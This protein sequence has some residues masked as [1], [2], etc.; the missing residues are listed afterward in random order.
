MANRIIAYF[1]LV[2]MAYHGRHD[3]QESL[4]ANND[5]KPNWDGSDPMKCV[6]QYRARV[7]VEYETNIGDAEVVKERRAS[8]ALRLTGGLSGKAWDIIE[9]LLAD[10]APMKVY[11]A[12]RL[13]LAALNTLDKEAVLTKPRKV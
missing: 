1:V 11:G 5:G 3:R 4:F 13:A 6:K 9:P 2:L 8:L 10:L 12:H 7:L